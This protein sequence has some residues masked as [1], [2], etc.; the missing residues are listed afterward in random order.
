M[1]EDNI[2]NDER[3]V[4]GG[5]KIFLPKPENY[6]KLIE[7]GYTDFEIDPT[8]LQRHAFPAVELSRKLFARGDDYLQDFLIPPMT[9]EQFQVNP[10][11][12]VKLERGGD[13]P[14]PTA[15]QIAEGRTKEDSNKDWW[16]YHPHLE[17]WLQEKGVEI[18]PDLEQLFYHASKLHN[19]A[20][21]MSL[22]IAR[23]LDSRLPGYNFLER[24]K[25]VMYLNVLRGLNYN[26]TRRGVNKAVWHSDRSI[27]GFHWWSTFHALVLRVDGKE[28]HPDEVAEDKVLVF[29]GQHIEKICDELKGKKVPHAVVERRQN[30]IEIAFEDRRIENVP[31]STLVSFI[32]ANMG[33][34]PDVLFQ[35]VYPGR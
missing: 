33:P 12:G 9:Q 32:K 29:F 18:T 8:F 6:D 23:E 14:N 22:Q 31:R 15:I 30:D 17:L 16:H 34:Q 35:P 7:V 10:D 28:I 5:G 27:W 4:E 19:A 13:I 21:F 24:I 25:T 20:N 1:T 2:L 11:Y 3:S 26:E